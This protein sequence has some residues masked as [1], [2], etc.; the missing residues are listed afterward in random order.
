VCVCLVLIGVYTLYKVYG[1]LKKKLNCIK[2][3]TNHQSS[4]NV[5]NIKIHTS[6]KSLSVAQVDLP[7]HNLSTLNNDI[8]V[9]RTK[10]LQTNKS[11]FLR[12]N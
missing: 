12:T 3:I 4:G 1:H 6:N 11:Y 2:A 8:Q 10:R 5:I 9:H 7:L